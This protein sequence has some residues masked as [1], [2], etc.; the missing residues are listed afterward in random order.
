MGPQQSK[1]WGSARVCQVTRTGSPCLCCCA[2][3]ELFPAVMWFC[4]I[5]LQLQTVIQ[6][7][8]I[9][10][11]A[12][13]EDV[14]HGHKHGLSRPRDVIAECP[15]IS[16][17]RGTGLSVCSGRD[18]T[19]NHLSRSCLEPENSLESPAAPESSRAQLLQ[20]WVRPSQNKTWNSVTGEHTR[21][22][23]AARLGLQGAHGGCRKWH[24]RNPPERS[25]PLSVVF[26][27]EFRVFREGQKCFSPGNGPVL[28]CPGM[29]LTL[30]IT[31][32]P[33][34]LGVAALPTHWEGEFGLRARA[35]LLAWGC[36]WHPLGSLGNTS[37]GQSLTGKAEGNSPEWKLCGQKFCSKCISAGSAAVFDEE[38]EQQTRDCFVMVTLQ[39]E[40][41]LVQGVQT[42]TVTGK[43]Q[44]LQ[45]VERQRRFWG[46]EQASSS[47]AQQSPSFPALGE[48]LPSLSLLSEWEQQEAAFSRNI[49]SPCTG[50]IQGKSRIQLLWLPALPTVLLLG[51][52]EEE[53]RE[54]DS[55][56]L[57]PGRYRAG[58]QV[59]LEIAQVLQGSSAR[60]SQSLVIPGVLLPSP[61]SSVPLWSAAFPLSEG[62]ASGCT[63]LDLAEELSPV[64]RD[65]AGWGHVGKALFKSTPNHSPI[66]CSDL[67]AVSAE[68]CPLPSVLCPPFSSLLPRRRLQLNSNQAFF[69]LVNGHS[70][71]SV[72]TPISEVY[73]SEKD[74][75]GFLYMVYASQETFGAPAV[76]VDPWPSPPLFPTHPPGKEPDVTYALSP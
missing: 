45:E 55:P 30:D 38:G 56:R 27:S 25:A 32:H 47:D 13:E 39:Q 31:P 72:S 49:H 2:E 42:K 58:D 65:R 73:E 48:L 66:L 19:L 5:H 70:M 9:P 40:L 3:C 17:P 60:I 21:K 64:L 14:F 43:S 71:V 12:P 36:S 59:S 44:L 53:D 18:A 28:R 23:D 61:S 24:F 29:L 41:V 34:P 69:L 7:S 1:G 35:L 20:Q 57:N 33:S 68:D 46:W 8:C 6:G 67:A 50:M 54:Q 16:I 11:R 26:F 76:W 15:A 22:A 74:E 37:S 10:C 62:P 4:L 52:R 63:R 75:D 51:E